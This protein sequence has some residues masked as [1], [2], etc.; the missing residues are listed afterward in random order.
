M[1]D[2]A[3]ITFPFNLKKVNFTKPNGDFT[4]CVYFG[5]DFEVRFV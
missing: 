4:H 5:T 3:K 1:V 2:F